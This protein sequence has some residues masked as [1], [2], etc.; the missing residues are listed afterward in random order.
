MLKAAR[1]KINENRAFVIVN[2]LFLTIYSLICFVNH[3][4][5]R[6]Y[7]LDLG[8]YTRALYDYAHFHASYG[9]VFRAA[10]ENILSDHFDLLLMFFLLLF[11]SYLIF[12]LLIIN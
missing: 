4:N 6:T 7:A 12:L 3:A 5:Y 9:E 8:A 1:N 10:P 11:V 2:L